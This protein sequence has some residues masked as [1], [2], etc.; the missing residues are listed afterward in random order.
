LILHGIYGR[1]GNWRGFARR[2]VA[3]LPDWGF[4]LVDLRMHGKSQGVPGPHTLASCADDVLELIR[5]RAAEGRET[6]CMLGHSFGGKVALA[7]RERQPLRTWVLDASPAPRPELAQG[8]QGSTVLAV[9][10]LLEQAPAHF[11]ERADFVAHVEAAGF[12]TALAQWLAMNLEARN[13]GYGLG[14]DPAAMRELLEDYYRVDLWDSVE[15]I[16]TPLRFA[17]ATRGSS[18]AEADQRRL[19]ELAERCDHLRT[20][21]IESGHWMHVD[22]P[23]ALA[24]AVVR[25]LR[26]A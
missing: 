3:Q 8:S 13:G 11:A 18:I 9:L 20:V 23:E 12:P 2:L 22:A 10:E 1:G 21:S 15:R 5:S 24:A 25:D 4:G 26:E 16:E 17:M 14:I 6:A 7:L 19:R